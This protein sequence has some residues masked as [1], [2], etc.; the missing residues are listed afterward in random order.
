M[1]VP[2]AKPLD[3][4]RSERSSIKWT[5]FAPDVLPLFVAE[6]DFA[7]A[8]SISAALIERI[9]ASDTG[10]LDGPGELAPAFA[11]FAADRW[12]WRVERAH[13]RLATDVSVGIV[14]ALRV[15]TR[16]GDGVVITPP[17]YP[18]F[19]ELV[20][21]AG[22]TRVEVPL[23]V[24]DG[25]HRLDLEGIERAFAAGATAILLCN[26]HNPIGFVHDATELRAL[27]ELAA[28]HD[29]AIV[30]DEVHAPLTHPGIRFSPVAP[31]AAAAGARSVVVTSA[32]KGWNLAGLKCSV[33]VAGDAR[34]AAALDRL[35]DEV[36]CRTSIL[37]LHAN[38][39][40][41]ADVEW[42]DAVVAKVTANDALLA[43]LLASELPEAVYHRPE[44]GYL[45]WVDLRGL[46]LGPSP[47][48]RIL[49]EARVALNDGATFGPGAAG[50]GRINLATEPEV[51]REAVARIA[52]LVRRTRA[53]E[54]GARG[55]STAA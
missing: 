27:A 15:L 25:G 3:V 12:D 38:V 2:A 45:A 19:F 54:A 55:A 40:A 16:P 49:D 28:R 37:G 13:V 42:L 43:E 41:Y 23:V 26:P 52:T 21:E 24:D 39:A 11:R 33:M 6:M 18:P 1:S 51:L 10:Y 46:D 31:I 5:R 44:A 50:F 4:I 20:E 48:R 47:Y 29:A 32:S 7:L 30:S 35:S 34:S 14:E 8:D 22:A 53:A 9:R 36:A 17:V